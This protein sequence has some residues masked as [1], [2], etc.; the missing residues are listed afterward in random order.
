M[1][2]NLHNFGLLWPLG[3]F[4]HSFESSISPLQDYDTLWPGDQNNW[5]FNKGGKILS[6]IL[7]QNTVQWRGA[8][9]HIRTSM[10]KA[11]RG[12]GV[13]RGFIHFYLSNC[14][15]LRI[16][17]HLLKTQKYIIWFKRNYSP[18]KILNFS[19]VNVKYPMWRK[20]AGSAAVVS[21]HKVDMD[22]CYERLQKMLRNIPILQWWNSRGEKVET[23]TS[24]QKSEI[25]YFYIVQVE[26]CEKTPDIL[27]LHYNNKYWQQRTTQNA[28]F[29]LYSAFYDKR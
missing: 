28:T 11:S 7:K 13:R 22:K 12:L 21:K 9:G 8:K 10:Q 29:Y 14:K 6:N 19:N 25:K 26:D 27:Q 16:D 2:L 24:E 23:S 17:K 5:Q 4:D 3:M 15:C 18:K 20:Q 1:T